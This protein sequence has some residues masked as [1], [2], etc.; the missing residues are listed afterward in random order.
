MAPYRVKPGHVLPHDG[1]V[2]PAGTVVD[3][4]PH[5]AADWA[6]SYRVE[7]IDRVDEP[8]ASMPTP[9]APPASA[10]STSAADTDPALAASSGSRRRQP[11]TPA[12]P[13][14]VSEE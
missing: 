8:A 7:P 2:L 11:P 4:A 14:V 12:A 3:L 6:V 13:P 1:A 9:A 10:S 5:V